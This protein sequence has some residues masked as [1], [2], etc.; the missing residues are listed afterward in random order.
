MAIYKT[1]AIPTL[2][3]EYNKIVKEIS[4]KTNYKGIEL[5]NEVMQHIYSITH[6]IQDYATKTALRVGFETIRFENQGKIMHYYIQDDNLIDFLSNT[7]IQNLDILKLKKENT[8]QSCIVHT[9]K[10]CYVLSNG[11]SDK[12][13]MVLTIHRDGEWINIS[14]ENKD[15]LKWLK[16]QGKEWYK[17]SCFAINLFY[18]INA[19]PNV[20]KDGFPDDVVK[21][22]RQVI[23][24][25]NNNHIIGVAPQIVQGYTSGKAP[26]FRQGFFR[27]YSNDRY[28][29]MKGKVQ[30]IEAT[31][32][33]GNRV[34]TILNKENINGTNN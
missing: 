24:R 3:K 8:M 22:Y 23:K 17:D 31:M 14:P 32:I 15:H 10:H 27:L 2:R 28:V 18:Y 4:I 16:K 11:L 1:D 25:F 20:I 21:S 30:F 33:K 29:N 34:K 26:H 19:F 6:Q 9:H 12:N 5:E 7:K 13:E